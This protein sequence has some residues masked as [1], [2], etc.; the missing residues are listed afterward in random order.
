VIV[1]DVVAMA[2]IVLGHR[3]FGDTGDAVDVVREAIE[4]TLPAA[5]AKR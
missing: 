1:D 2:P 5:V 4:A 3:I